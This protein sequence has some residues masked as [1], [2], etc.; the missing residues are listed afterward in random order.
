MTALRQTQRRPTRW[1]TCAHEAGHAV[2]GILL[3][4][5]VESI[6][7]EPSC[8]DSGRCTFDAPI[9]A[10][11]K[12]A[13][14]LAGDVAASLLHPGGSDKLHA[15]LAPHARGRMRQAAQTFAAMGL[16]FDP[17]RDLPSDYRTLAPAAEQTGVAIDVDR[18][19]GAA[20]DLLEPHRAIIGKLAEELF[21]AGTVN[22]P[23]VH[24]LVDA[25]LL[26]TAAELQNLL[27]EI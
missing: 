27:G 11:H 15:L 13:I 14:S 18:A 3:G 2:A 22:G 12:L 25:E 7:V 5:R 21:L 1:L 17:A 23:R 20:A 24:E 26:D 8:L 16:D 6:T 19:V 4:L 9:P 10:E